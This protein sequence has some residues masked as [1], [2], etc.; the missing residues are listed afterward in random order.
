[1]LTVRGRASPGKESA[2]NTAIS[3]FRLANT[4]VRTDNAIPR[5]EQPNGVAKAKR[6]FVMALFGLVLAFV[7]TLGLELLV[8]SDLTIPISTLIPLLLAAVLLAVCAVM[9]SRIYHLKAAD[10]FNSVLLDAQSNPEALDHFVNRQI[11]GDTES[12]VQRILYDLFDKRNRAEA[13]AESLFDAQLDL[14]AALATE[15]SSAK[16]LAVYQTFFD[17]DAIGMVLLNDVFRVVDANN[18]ALNV[19]GYAKPEIVEVDW[20]DTLNSKHW[21]EVR[22]ILVSI[23]AGEINE[24]EGH[25]SGTRP[26]GEIYYGDWFGRVL[27][28][29]D[30]GARTV[31]AFL[32]DATERYRS[33]AELRDVLKEQEILIEDQRQF[34]YMFDANLLGMCITTRDDPW[35]KVNQKYCEMTGYTQDELRHLSWRELTHPDDDHIAKQA[36]MDILSGTSD[37]FE[38]EIR[39][40]RKDDRVINVHVAGKGM[41]NEDGSLR[42]LVLMVQDVSAKLR[43]EYERK[44][45]LDLLR[46]ILD[47]IPDGVV[48]LSEQSVIVS[49]NP[50]FN[51]MFNLEPETVVGQPIARFVPDFC[52]PDNDNDVDFNDDTKGFRR[53]GEEFPVGYRCIRRKTDDETRFTALVYDNT[54]TKKL[55]LDIENARDDAMAAVRAKSAFLANMSHELRTP[56]NGILGMLELVNATE[57]D[58]DQA[59]YIRTAS[60]S[61]RHLLALIND[62]LDYSKLDAGQMEQ[63]LRPVDLRQVVEEVV[64]LLSVSVKDKD[65]DL[66]SIISPEVPRVVLADEKRIRQVMINLM[67]NAIKFTPAG[68]VTILVSPSN[69]RGS[70]KRIRFEVRDTGVGIDDAVQATIFEAFVQAD[71]STTREYGGTGL[72]LSVCR[73][74]VALMGGEISLESKVGVGSAFS[75][76][77]EL[78]TVKNPSIDVESACDLELKLLVCDTN[79]NFARSLRSMSIF[80]SMTVDA[81]AERPGAIELLVEADSR[82]A[83]YDAIL[84]EAVDDDAA[85]ENILMQI[86]S[87]EFLHRPLVIVMGPPERRKHVSPG[88]TPGVDGFL[89]K[90]LTSKHVQELLHR[91]FLPRTFSPERSS[92]GSFDLGLDGAGVRILA[93]DDVEVNLRVIAGMLERFNVDVDT[94]SN[95]REAVQAAKL[96]RYQMILMDCQM[97]ELDGWR[98]TQQIRT[99]EEYKSIPIIAMTAAVLEED[100]ERS[101]A[102]GMDDLLAKPIQFD[103]LRTTLGKHLSAMNVLSTQHQRSTGKEETTS[104]PPEGNPVSAPTDLVDAGKIQELLDLL[105]DESVAELIDVFEVEFERRFSELGSAI[106]SSDLPKATRLCHSLKGASENIGAKSLGELCREYEHAAKEGRDLRSTWQEDLRE[107]YDSSIIGLRASMTSCA[108]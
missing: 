8:P 20:F 88:R 5:P 79:P 48:D 107:T 105:G 16:S 85:L 44:K 65:V 91:L 103:D 50:A 36:L 28:D 83:P 33:E 86:S 71:V 42:W 101:N 17:A 100:Q 37:E 67:G 58:E 75:F 95:G 82:E 51:T 97:P 78:A 92:T 19:M 81:V 70:A 22:G 74:L 45:A 41:L 60:D 73:Q 2:K 40:V 72:G 30:S 26:N 29:E 7:L 89:S 69:D 63:D 77:I 3:V 62:V 31:V 80:R 34:R 9:A 102:A 14:E 25:W 57:L 94:A 87:M 24:F 90:P 106:A 47:T 49:A 11:F 35:G 46:D 104:E 43:A 56:L 59:D 66:I 54:K 84:L 6:T 99:F 96:H 18:Y 12:T 38:V 10:E 13:I 68:E 52:I 98:A 39:Y 61:G 108:A 64:E 23:E 1:M 93:V 27:D 53:G 4:F 55:I 21:S 32:L 76:E 15:K